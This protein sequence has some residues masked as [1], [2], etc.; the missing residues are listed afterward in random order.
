[1]HQRSS[2]TPFPLILLLA[3]SA[4]SRAADND[5]GPSMVI[6]AAEEAAHGDTLM[7]ECRFDDAEYWIK[8]ALKTA[9]KS[10][11][12]TTLER[13]VAGS[14]VGQMTVKLN[15]LQRERKAWDRAATEAR[16]QL[17][18]NHIGM[19]RATLDQSAAPACDPRFAELRNEIATR[20]QQAAEWVRKG[21]S[22]AIRYPRTAENY[23][24]QANAIDPDR[25]GLQEKLQYVERRIPSR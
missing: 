13:D 2:I 19:A 23:Y 4:I 5:Q 20:D 15:D 22:Q 21:D 6:A 17:D 8:E 1:M 11:G 24:L 12:G 18:G 16:R 9:K 25:P 3:L 14:A 7:N 10:R